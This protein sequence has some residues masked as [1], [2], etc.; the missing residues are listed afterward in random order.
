[1][2]EISI[3][4]EKR[5]CPNCKSTHINKQGFRTTRKAGKRQRYFCVD[6]GHSFY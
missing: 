3:E 4:V 6:C 5:Q 2:S 1:M